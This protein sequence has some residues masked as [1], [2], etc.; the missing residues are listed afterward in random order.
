MQRV[1]A[2]TKR[3]FSATNGAGEFA[4]DNFGHTLLAVDEERECVGRSRVAQR[5]QCGDR[6][7]PGP[8]V[9]AATPA[10]GHSPRGLDE[11]WG[12]HGV[13]VRQQAQNAF[14]PRAQHLSERLTPFVVRPV[15]LDAN[16][17]WLFESVFTMRRD[18]G[19]ECAHCGYLISW[20]RARRLRRR[21]REAGG[22]RAPI[23]LPTPFAPVPCG[24]CWRMI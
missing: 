7:E 19:C 4:L 14:S 11:C 22:F 20:H 1:C 12:P 16:T 10:P 23:T 15:R 5:Q 2:Q 8:R 9:R 24:W 18:H 21:F 6:G 3:S 17:P 13:V